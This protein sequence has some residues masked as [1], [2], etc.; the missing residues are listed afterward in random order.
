MNSKAIHKNNTRSLTEPDQERVKTSS[1]SIY[2]QV[3]NRINLNLLNEITKEL[4]SFIAATY[5]TS[6]FANIIIPPRTTGIHSE[7][8]LDSEVKE[9]I[10]FK[11]SQNRANGV[12]PLITKRIKQIYLKN[13]CSLHIYFSNSELR[14]QIQIMQNL[15]IKLISTLYLTIMDGK[16]TDEALDISANI[17]TE[18]YQSYLAI[19][20]LI[21]GKLKEDYSYCESYV[22]LS[23]S[24]KIRL[25]NKPHKD[26]E[27]FYFSQVNKLVNHMMKLFIN[28]FIKTGLSKE[29][30]EI[31]EDIS[32]NIDNY[33]DYFLMDLVA[34]IHNH[35][36]DQPPEKKILDLNCDP[37]SVTIL[38][39]ASKVLSVSMKLPNSA[40]ELVSSI[41]FRPHAVSFIQEIS[42][43]Y[44]VIVYSSYG[45][46][47]AIINYLFR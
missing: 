37:K 10:K 18:F 46:N 13:E 9:T 25:F 11:E 21:L 1:S 36:V 27:A 42:F 35:S 29:Y 28:K 30:S 12:L 16:Q 2:Y 3:E 17:F 38:I 23:N 24:I 4:F 32:F 20:Y 40:R 41:I 47:V 39:P 6:N 8:N 34:K 26:D 33:S 5:S 31:L 15:E 19:G 43:Y 45:E 7:Q 14:K 22:E 44:N